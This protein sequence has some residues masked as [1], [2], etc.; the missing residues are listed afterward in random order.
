LMFSM[1]LKV[2]GAIMGDGNQESRKRR[3]DGRKVSAR[4]QGENYRD[5]GRHFWNA[6]LNS[7][8]ALMLMNPYRIPD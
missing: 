2:S 8:S 6:D 7:Q 3:V 1:W 4:A 5:L